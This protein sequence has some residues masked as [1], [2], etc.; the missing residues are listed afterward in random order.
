MTADS[1]P[2]FARSGGNLFSPQEVRALMEVEFQRGQRHGYPVCCLALRPDRLDQLCLIHGQES[3]D[4]VLNA[5]VDLVRRTIR[6]GDLLG[7]TEDERL[8]LI[9]PH[10]VPTALVV[11]CKRIIAGAASLVFEGGTGTHR[12]TLSIGAS[13]SRHAHALDFATLERVALDGLAVAEAGG[14]DRWVESELYELESLP[15][16]EPTG[17]PAE[18][19]AEQLFPDYRERLV[20][21]V[22]AGG[23]LEDAAREL[24][25]EIVRRALEGQVVQTD[26]SPVT[27][28]GQPEADLLR[29]R[30][31]KLTRSLGISEEE[32]RELRAFKQA[33]LER[34]ESMAGAAGERTLGTEDSL[35]ADLM[36]TIFEANRDLQ[37]RSRRDAG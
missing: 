24:A 15:T 7:F 2:T 17:A 12:T 30:I 16:A 18:T 10:L 32:L 9:L 27:E 4:E 21:M 29:R 22:S 23:G 11:L 8:I 5:V 13:H 37:R 26:G 6:A 14:G 25:D 36:R 34:G 28:S 33:S 19:A 31:A 20:D 35:R 3:K 1:T